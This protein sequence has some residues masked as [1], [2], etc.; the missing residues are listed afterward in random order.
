MAEQKQ[1]RFE[2]DCSWERSLIEA[3]G[4]G[5]LTEAIFSH[6]DT[7][8]PTSD[9]FLVLEQIWH[10]LNIDSDSCCNWRSPE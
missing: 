7:S 5:G 3:R 1:H 10:A 8:R 6:L 2:K 4:L 9:R